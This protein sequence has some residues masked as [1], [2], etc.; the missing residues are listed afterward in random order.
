MSDAP[1]QSYTLARKII[2]KRLQPFL[3]GLRK[4]LSRPGALK[5]PYR[6]V[7]S[8]TQAHPVRQANLV[9]LCGLIEQ[10]GVLDAS[11]KCGVLDGGTAALMAY[12]TKDRPIHLLDSWEGLPAI[13]TEDGDGG[14]WV[15][16]VVGSPKRVQTIMR[17]PSVHCC[18]SSQ[19]LVAHQSLGF[20][21]TRTPLAV[22]QMTNGYPLSL[23]N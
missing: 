16:Q 21:Q 13:T 11:S 2:P 4:R 15:G 12:C 17:E 3:R 23:K 7:F 9:R 1:A 6:S 14:R 22:A 18:F 20:L 19:A 5:E 8:Y 10:R